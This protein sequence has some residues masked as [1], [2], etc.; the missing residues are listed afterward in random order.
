MLK[1]TLTFHHFDGEWDYL[2]ESDPIACYT[3]P[4]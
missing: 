3:G 2:M 4:T 1:L